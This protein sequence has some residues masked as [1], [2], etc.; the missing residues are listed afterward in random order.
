M[1]SEKSINLGLG[2]DMNCVLCTML[3]VVVIVKTDGVGYTVAPQRALFRCD[4][5]IDDMV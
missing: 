2:H 1:R 5:S 4:H 3:V